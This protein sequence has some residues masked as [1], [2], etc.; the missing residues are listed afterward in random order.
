MVARH[1]YVFS[2]DSKKYPHI[3]VIMEEWKN[4][5]EHKYSNLICMAI[6]TFYQK[7]VQEKREA[8][9]MLKPIGG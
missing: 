8:R 6:E 7:K 2:V 1:S 5:K 3:P 9:E 4:D